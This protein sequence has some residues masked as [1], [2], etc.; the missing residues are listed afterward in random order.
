MLIMSVMGVISVSRQFFSTLVGMWSRS[1]DLD[2]QAKFLI[3]R[4]ISSSVTRS[5]PF[6]L[7]LISGFCTDGM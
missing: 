6:I 3:I 7:D 4:L 5:I 2:G 1:H